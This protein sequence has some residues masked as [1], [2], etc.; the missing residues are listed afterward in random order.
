[1]AVN[2][3]RIKAVVELQNEGGTL[4]YHSVLTK[5]EIKEF[6]GKSAEALDCYM[7]AYFLLSRIKS[8]IIID[9]DNEILLKE[10][11]IS[12]GGKISQ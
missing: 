4:R 6:Q 1:M 5:G 11:I 9:F 12:L 7:E 10:K 8:K 2:V 3:S